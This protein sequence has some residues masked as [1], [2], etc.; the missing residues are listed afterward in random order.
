MLPDVVPPPHPT[1]IGLLFEEVPRVQ[2]LALVVIESGYFHARHN[3]L[4]ASGAAHRA[5]PS[6]LSGSCRSPLPYPAAGLRRCRRRNRPP[7]PPSRTR[8]PGRPPALW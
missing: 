1:V 5:A 7:C 8:A 3:V 6:S 2:E 4:K